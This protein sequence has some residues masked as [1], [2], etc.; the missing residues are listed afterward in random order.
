[1][2]HILQRLKKPFVR[3]VKNVLFPS[4]IT[5]NFHTQYIKR[6]WVL[7]IY[8]TSSNRWHSIIATHL[9][10]HGVLHAVK[11]TTFM[12]THSEFNLTSDMRESFRLLVLISQE[13]FLCPLKYEWQILLS[14]AKEQIG[15]DVEERISLLKIQKRRRRYNRA[16]TPE[17]NQNSSVT[18][19]IDRCLRK[20]CINRENQGDKLQMVNWKVQ[21]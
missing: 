16:F 18:A 4:I 9:C 7:N 14:A 11:F 17:F 19:R 10:Q 13:F 21:N 6:F 2:K 3:H 20:L 8:I 12:R 5:L 1:M 15:F